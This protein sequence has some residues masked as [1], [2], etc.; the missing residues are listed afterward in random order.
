MTG[1]NHG[2]TPSAASDVEDIPKERTLS[3]LYTIVS[4]TDAQPM[5]H[6]LEFLGTWELECVANSLN[7]LT[8]PDGKSVSHCSLFFHSLGILIGRDIIFTLDADNRLLARNLKILPGIPTPISPAESEPTSNHLNIPNPFKLM[9]KSTEHR[10]DKVVLKVFLDEPQELGQLSLESALCGF[11]LGPGSNNLFGVM[12]T[13]MEL[14]VSVR[15]LADY[16]FLTDHRI[17]YRMLG[18]S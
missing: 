11:I 3:V 9:S 7:I 18:L 2:G 16:V 15:L 14:V 1:S 10:E 8:N 12:W 17:G 5:Q 6:N 13:E 4:G